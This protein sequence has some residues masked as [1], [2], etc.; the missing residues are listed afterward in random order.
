M[1]NIADDAKLG[2][3]NRSFAAYVENV[4]KEFSRLPGIMPKTVQ[5]QGDSQHPLHLAYF[6]RAS[7]LFSHSYELERSRQF[8]DL[9]TKCVAVFGSPEGQDRPSE[10][11]VVFD[12]IQHYQ[13]FHFF[14]RSGLYLDLYNKVRVNTETYFEKFLL[15]FNARMLERVQL[16]PILNVLFTWP[17]EK[18]EEEDDVNRLKFGTFEIR[19]FTPEELAE[20]IGNAVNRVFYPEAALEGRLLK[21]VA[22][23]PFLLRRYPIVYANS[24]MATAGRRPFVFAHDDVDEFPDNAI[25]LL[26]LWDWLPSGMAE[27][28]AGM[29]DQPPVILNL[30]LAFTWKIDK[31][32][33]SHP[34]M[35]NL[36]PNLPGLVTYDQTKILLDET[37][38][39]RLRE[40]IATKEDFP[41]KINLRECGWEFL[42]NATGFLG[43][44]FL[45]KPGLT[46]LLWNLVALEALVGEKENLTRSLR[47]RTGSLLARDKREAKRIEGHI[48]R[49]Y[50]IRCNLVHG[51]LSQS[52]K[53]EAFAQ[54]RDLA[55]KAVVKFIDILRQSHGRF[56]EEGLSAR[57]YPTREKLLSELDKRFG[58]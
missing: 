37:D 43:K 39:K 10:S 14:R 11:D 41:D 31:D 17:E 9:L 46:Q 24:K 18:D 34:G 53:P 20:V 49:L 6:N 32:L 5:T 8:H 45:L 16:S 15:S 25:R 42:S 56:A 57:E 51:K 21:Q 26:A 54:A 22:E 13:V 50:D 1:T 36:I 29:Q 44:A 47:K 23:Y 55:R 58:K 38:I 12:P 33:L 2:D 4:K 28:G 35:L 19:M 7:N 27:Q 48:H 30:D 40:F 3:L 52:A